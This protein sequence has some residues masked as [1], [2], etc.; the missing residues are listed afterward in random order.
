LKYISK[1]KVF[2]TTLTLSLFADEVISVDL[3]LG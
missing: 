3:C 2:Y 1:V